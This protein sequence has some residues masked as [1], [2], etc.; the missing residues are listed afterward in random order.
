[1]KGGEA[2]IGINIAFDQGNASLCSSI[3]NDQALPEQ[4]SVLQKCPVVCFK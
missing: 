2:N 3:G 1:M 4:R